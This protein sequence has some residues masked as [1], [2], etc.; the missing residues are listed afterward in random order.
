MKFVLCLSRI[1]SSAWQEEL[2]ALPEYEE[3][4]DA[5]VLSRTESRERAEVQ[6]QRDALERKIDDNKEKVEELL[7]KLAVR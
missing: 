6:R 4:A 5:L 2:S 3:V 1:Q 7:E